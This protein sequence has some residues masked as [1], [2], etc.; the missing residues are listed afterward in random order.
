MDGQQTACDEK[1]WYQ[2]NGILI[3]SNQ[4]QVCGIILLCDLDLQ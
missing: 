1:L 2:S 3:L 4:S